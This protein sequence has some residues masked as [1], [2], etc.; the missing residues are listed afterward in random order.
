MDFDLRIVKLTER[1]EALAQ[2]IELMMLE[3]NQWAAESKQRAAVVDRQIS[4]LL[5]GLE[6]LTHVAGL[7]QHRLDRMEG[8]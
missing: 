5:G 7:H 1:H 2:A 6:K 8:V 3:H 4:Q